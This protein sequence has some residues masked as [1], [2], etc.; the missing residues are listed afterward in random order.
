[1][2]T[3][4]ATRIEFSHVGIPPI[5]RANALLARAER[6]AADRCGIDRILQLFDYLGFWRPCR[7]RSELWRRSTC[8]RTIVMHRNRAI[9]HLRTS[10]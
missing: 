2:V 9:G 8:D 7:F 1:M 10:C 5:A 3:R 6:P 4:V